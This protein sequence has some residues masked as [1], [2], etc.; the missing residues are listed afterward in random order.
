MIRALLGRLFLHCI[1]CAKRRAFKKET[2]GL[3]F[4]TLTDWQISDLV[5]GRPLDVSRP[6]RRMGL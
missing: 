3:D 2:R 6:S 5:H 4:A 1:D